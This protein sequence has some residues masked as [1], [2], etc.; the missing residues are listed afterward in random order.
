MSLF[1]KRKPTMFEKALLVVGVLVIAAGFFLIN[2][3]YRIDPNLSWSLI[4]ASFLWLVLIL[5][6]I[7]ANASQ[8]I[9]EELSILIRET[10]TEIQLLRKDMSNY[11]KK[12][13]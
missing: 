10:K 9:K 13:K 8:D 7:L 11:G 1:E 12:K 5:M 2:S 4:H 6:L 3:M